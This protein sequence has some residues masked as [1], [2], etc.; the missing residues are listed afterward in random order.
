METINLINTMTKATT[1]KALS[2]TASTGKVIT[3]ET[4]EYKVGAAVSGNVL[5]QEETSKLS[6]TTNKVKQTVSELNSFVQNIQRSIQFSVHDE[7]GQSV[8]TVT[9]KDSGD[10]IRSFPSEKVLEIAAYLAENKAQADDS[11]RGLL[12]ND[13]A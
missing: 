12:V 13:S 6:S 7:T 1:P 5:P 9:D 8:I 2:S 11:V 4:V 3:N 10:V